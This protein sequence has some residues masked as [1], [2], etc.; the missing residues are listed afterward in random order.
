MPPSIRNRL[1]SATNAVPRPMPRP[2]RP[3]S[4]F[5]SRA[6]ARTSADVS[7]TRS[8]TSTPNARRPFTASP[9]MLL[10]QCLAQQIAESDRDQQRSTRMLFDLMLDARPE[11][12]E[13]GLAKPVGGRLH[14]GRNLLRHL[15]G[16]SLGHAD[17]DRA[18]LSGEGSGA[19]SD[20]RAAA[21]K[22]VGARV[23]GV[24]QGVLQR[25]RTIA[26]G[27]AHVGELVSRRIGD[28]ACT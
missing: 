1:P 8:R 2:I 21:A 9:A 25:S 19:R 12:V 3:N 7:S 28:V 20:R 26:Y 5:T 14:A 11:I 22:L 27:T 15:G 10:S 6:S 13:I 17:A 23:E 24:G 16:T 4:I 18:P